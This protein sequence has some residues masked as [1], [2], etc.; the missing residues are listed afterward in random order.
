MTI[1]K[2]DEEREKIEYNIV[3]KIKERISKRLIR[4]NNIIILK[5]IDTILEL[6]EKENHLD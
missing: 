5:Q 6:S 2:N 4:N 3:S 1:L